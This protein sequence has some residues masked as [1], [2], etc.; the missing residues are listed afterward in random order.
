MKVKAYRTILVVAVTALVLVAGCTGDGASVDVPGADD[1]ASDGGSGDGAGDGEGGDSGDD[2]SGDSA[3]DASGSAGDGGDVTTDDGGP[4]ADTGDDGASADGDDP[5]SATPTPGSDGGDDATPPAD[6]GATQSFAD[7]EHTRALAEA[8][9]YTLEYTIDGQFTG[10]GGPET[11]L[12]G[13]EAVNLDTGERYASLENRVEADNFTFEYYLPPGSDTA[14]QRGMGQV[15]E[16]PA[17]NAVFFNFTDPGTGE[18]AEEWPEF[19]EAGSAETAMGPATKW[20]VDSPADLPEATREEY[21]TIESVEF[22]V[23]VDDDTGV[24]A[25]YDY[26]ISYVDDGQRGNFRMTIELSDL[27][28][29]TVTKPDWA[30]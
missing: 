18:S 19:R 5:V 23:W 29:T 17:E 8:G 27:G 22:T 9:S 3:G 13:S 12:V 11:L 2:T 6:S 26:R 1:G 25:K 15:M 21:D 30:P 20:V 10:L 14:Y 28:S 7:G 4:D 24:I 16:V